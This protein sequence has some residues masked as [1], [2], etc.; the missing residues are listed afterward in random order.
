MPLGDVPVWQ[1]GA[2]GWPAAW[3]L[4]HAILTVES[5]RGFLCL[6]SY[7]CR[8]LKWTRPFLKF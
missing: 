1:V 5:T 2:W 3:S 8:L 6:M 4:G 7:G